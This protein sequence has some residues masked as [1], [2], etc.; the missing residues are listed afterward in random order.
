[1][2]IMAQALRGQRWQIYVT[3][4]TLSTDFPTTTGRYAQRSADVFGPAGANG[5]A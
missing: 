3:G 1:M 4:M 2:T 5:R